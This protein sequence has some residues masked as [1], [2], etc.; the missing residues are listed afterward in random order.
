MKIDKILYI[1]ASIFTTGFII[2]ASVN[3][4]TTAYSLLAV[5]ILILFFGMVASRMSKR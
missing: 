5:A 3:D 4:W 2:A 1:I